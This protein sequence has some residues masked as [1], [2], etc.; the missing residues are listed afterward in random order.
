VFNANA[1]LNG[2]ALELLG[3]IEQLR[4]DE[5]RVRLLGRPRGGESFRSRAVLSALV[6]AIACRRPSVCGQHDRPV[7]P[8][9][10]HREQTQPI[11]Y[12]MPDVHTVD[13]PRPGPTGASP[14]PAS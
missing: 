14:G 1:V 2:E 13:A 8:D 7:S 11:A 12:A 5:G 6:E 9:S 10:D 4:V 3:D